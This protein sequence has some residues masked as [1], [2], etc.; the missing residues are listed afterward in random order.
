MIGGASGNYVRPGVTLVPAVDKRL[1]FQALDG[2]E[3]ADRAL[4][5]RLGPGSRHEIPASV[6]AKDV[7][8][9]VQLNN[10]CLPF[11]VDVLCHSGVWWLRGAMRSIS[12]RAGENLRVRARRRFDIETMS[13]GLAT[14]GDVLHLAI[15]AP[16]ESGAEGCSRHPAVFWTDEPTRPLT[17]QIAQ[18]VFA[19]PD[20][21]WSR[22]HAAA[23]LDLS[24]RDLS[25][26]MLMEGAALMPLVCEQRLMRTLFD[27]SHGK[28]MRATHGFASRER[29]DTAFFD[30]FGVCVEQLAIIGRSGMVRWS[31]M[32][33]G[34][35]TFSLATSAGEG[36]L[37]A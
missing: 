35:S 21:P 33:S 36:V 4:L 30:R 16:K 1:A 2:L 27:A 24:M 29:R 25:A 28:G 14:G 19:Q 11:D 31:G 3:L 22:A 8:R 26:R 20:A 23:L 9:A 32:S 7:A 6:R 17:V 15:A 34:T 12:L 18:A 13:A 10:L 5:G 37:A